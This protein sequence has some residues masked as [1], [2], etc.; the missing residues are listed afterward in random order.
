VASPRDFTPGDDHGY[1]EGVPY[2]L[3]AAMWDPESID[4]TEHYWPYERG[5]AAGQALVPAPQQR[6]RSDSAQSPFGASPARIPDPQL[7]PVDN[8]PEGGDA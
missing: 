1:I 5:L 6:E 4:R 2:S 8:D 3:I 7:A